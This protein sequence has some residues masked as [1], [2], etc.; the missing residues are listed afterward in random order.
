MIEGR[1]PN[2]S[3]RSKEQFAWQWMNLV[4]AT[5]FAVMEQVDGILRIGVDETNK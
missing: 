4:R 5:V 1:S 2:I 3:E